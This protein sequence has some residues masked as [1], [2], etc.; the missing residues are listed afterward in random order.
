MHVIGSYQ[1]RRELEGSLTTTRYSKVSNRSDKCTWLQRL[2]R[3]SGVDNDLCHVV[4]QVKRG[5]GSSRLAGCARPLHSVKLWNFESTMNDIYYFLSWLTFQSH[6]KPVVII[7]VVGART[8]TGDTRTVFGWFC[9]Q[10]I[11]AVCL[12]VIF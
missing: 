4:K 10:S 11:I 9:P 3:Y 12:F 6:Q 8:H 5:P 7:T 2:H 1:S